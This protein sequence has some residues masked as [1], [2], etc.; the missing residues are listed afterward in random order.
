MK[1]FISCDIEGVTTTTLWDQTRTAP[2]KLSLTAP[3][4]AQMTREVVAACEGAIAAGA[5][6]ILIK[7]AHGAAINIDPMALPECC[8][9][10]RNWERHPYSMVEGIDSSF[11]AAM[12]VGYHSAAGRD[13]N[14]LSHT[15]TGN[16]YAI[17]V[18]GK[19]FSEFDFFSY[20]VALE[21]VPSVLL[22]GD[23]QLCDGAIES[24]IHQKLMTVA[25][26]EGKG[27]STRSI[28]PSL[29]CKRIRETAEAA[30]KQDLTGAVPALP[31]HFVMEI[32][33]KDHTMATKMSYYPGME[34]ISDDTIQLE[35]DNL[36]D[37]LRAINFVL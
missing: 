19:K 13:G 25:V 29:A 2:E 22:T 21:G 5:T 23:K 33:Y 10:I 24:G 28:S 27:G 26:K 11:D 12:F 35:S 20:A 8:E 30:L 15:K 34:K 32:S 3:F 17:R 6:Y 1:V 9:L 4:Q 37:L 7:D 18:N 14:P 36:V 31:E 16:A